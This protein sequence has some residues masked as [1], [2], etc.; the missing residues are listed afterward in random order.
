MKGLIFLT[1]ADGQHIAAEMILRYYYGELT[2]NIEVKDCTG[3]T[4]TDLTTYIGTLTDGDFDKIHVLVVADESGGTGKVSFDQLALLMP[5]LKTA[6]I[7]AAVLAGDAQANITATEII[8]PATGSESDDAYNGMIVAVDVGKVGTNMLY[9]YIKDYTG[10]T[11][12][13]SV[14]TTT[15]AVTT[16]DSVAVYDL[17]KATGPIYVHTG[18]VA[19]TVFAAMYSSMTHLPLFIDEMKASTSEYLITGNATSVANTS[20]VGSLTHTGEFVLAAYDGGDYY[21]G[22]RSATT[23]MGQVR[24]IVS[25]TANVL[26]LDAPWDP[27]PTGTIEYE[28]VLNRW[29]CLNDYFL[30]YAIRYSFG[31]PFFQSKLTK[32]ISVIDTTKS[33][34][35]TTK[36]LVTQDL[37]ALEELRALGETI[38]V[39]LGRGIV[40]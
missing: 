4:K 39:S 32:F 35:T 38:M 7:P 29:R 13:A 1:Q 27:L 14:N 36:Y 30:Q 34:T 15:I 18:N 5:K 9:R 11:T 16:T 20:N 3:V 12:L 33:F 6:S 8:L 26:T 17:V 40:S 2:T 10:T 31:T 37:E 23:G 21:V 24:K 19:Y 28:I 22:I 25:N